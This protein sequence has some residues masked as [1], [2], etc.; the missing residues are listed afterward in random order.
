MKKLPAKTYTMVLKNLS[1]PNQGVGVEIMVSY[2]KSSKMI[3]CHNL[4]KLKE[5]QWELLS[6]RDGKNTDSTEDTKRR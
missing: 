5:L 1:T 2:Q 6:G 3:E 4:S